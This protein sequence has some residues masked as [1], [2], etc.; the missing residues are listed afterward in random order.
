MQSACAVL[1]RD[2]WPFR[3]YRMFFTLFHIR[4]DFRKKVAEHKMCFFI[5]STTFA[6]NISHSKKHSALYYKCASV[7]MWNA[8]NSCQI[9]IRRKFFRHIFEK[10]S[11]S[12]FYISFFF[13]WQ[14]SLLTRSDGQA[15]MTMLT[16]AFRGAANAPKKS[17]KLLKGTRAV[18]VVVM[19]VVVVVV[20]IAA[21]IIVVVCCIPLL[22]WV[23]A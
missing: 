10:Y 5:S 15:D 4:H 17:R 12:E 6:W 23:T 9:L 1:C 20:V 11:T 21:K 7:A 3:L 22:Q 19:V 14:S 2:L 18:V 13:Q 8:R 16:V